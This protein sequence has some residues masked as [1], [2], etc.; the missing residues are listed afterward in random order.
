MEPLPFTVRI[1]RNDEQLAKAVYIRSEAYGR[2]WPNLTAHLRDP[3]PQDRDPN[4]LVLLAESKANGEALGTMRIDTNL[5]SRLQIESD[6]AFPKNITSSPT[7]YVTRLGVKQGRLG[8]L[9]KLSLFK[10][11]Y[12]YCLAN[13]LA[14]VLA[15]VRPP[16]DRDY[17][18]LG[19]QDL[20]EGGTLVPITSSGGV[21]VR[22]LSLDVTN[23]ERQWHAS[24]H[25]LYAFMFTTFHPDI[26]LFTSVSGM[27]GQPRRSRSLKGQPATPLQWLEVPLV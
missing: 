15:G 23:T 9:V 20:V 5:R 22:I 1:A 16:N 21:P 25:P 26:E 24:N 2:H 27:W 11:L 12:R 4:S 3:E 19:F 17:I 7:A 14:W 8:T 18:R 13:Q 10:S 6:F